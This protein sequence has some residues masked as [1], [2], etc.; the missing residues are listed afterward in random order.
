RYRDYWLTYL[1][2][3]E[4]KGVTQQLAKIEMRRRL[5]LISAML[6]HKGEVDGML[7]GTWGTTATHLQYIDQVIGKRA[8][9]KTYACMNGLILPGRQVMLV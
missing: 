6:L 8:G 2:M 5:T 9:V 4:R 1:R 3:T 7:C